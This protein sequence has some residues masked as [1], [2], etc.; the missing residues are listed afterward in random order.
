[1]FHVKHS[2]ENK[3]AVLSRED[4]MN[5]VKEIVGDRTDDA[6]LKFIEDCNDTITDDREQ[7][8][9][10]YEAEV[11][12]KKDLDESWRVKFKERFYSSDTNTQTNTNTNTNKDENEH[13]NI[14]DNRSEEQKK[15]ENISV[16][17]LFSE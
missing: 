10:K 12:A 7:W 8:R 4:F 14:F 6:A 2:K 3:M 5:A 17:D 9:A 16:N 15:A 11:Q 1:M 13:N